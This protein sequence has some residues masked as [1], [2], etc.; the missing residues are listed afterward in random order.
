M[1]FA[2]NL[3]TGE[4]IWRYSYRDVAGGGRSAPALV[5]NRLV[6]GYGQGLIALN[7]TTGMQLWRSGVVGAPTSE[8][9]SS[10]AVTGPAGSQVAFVGDTA[11]NVYAFDLATGARQWSSRAGTLVYSSAAVSGAR[12]FFTSNNGLL[13]AYGLGG[14]VSSPPN[15]TV[16]NP[17]RNTTLPAASNATVTGSASDDV[18]VSEVRVAV[19]D[20]NAA[21]WWNAATRAW[22]RDFFDNP[23]SATAAGA[24]STNWTFTF[25]V[26]VTGG[27]FL[28]QASAI[29]TDHQSDPTAAS[30]N[31]TVSSSGNP[32][33]TTITSPKNNTVIPFPNG[34]ASFPIDV[35]GQAT[36]SG[37]AH[38]GI[39]TVNVVV[40]NLQHSEY[41]CG[42]A[43]CPD[44]AGGT[45]AWSAT[46]TT[47]HADLVS[48]G[49]T[50]TAWKLTFQAYDHP[51]DYRI[52]AWAVD[53]DREKDI[54]HARVAKV[55]VRDPGTGC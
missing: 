4:Q 34:R 12:V 48:P 3:R 38:P 21:R 25:P 50:S 1:I 29:D 19:R 49:A 22:Q 31:F 16:T 9:I 7:A 24:T 36:D 41:W 42:P 28:V 27:V 51:H 26:A 30:T 47:V 17:L 54:T 53:K 13:Y 15:T 43:G 44:G 32:P 45:V 11:G 20:Q 33:D 6:F 35:S 5:G 23:A 52:T 40:E 14:G 2:L 8:V 39:A 55:C 18:G 46:F 37:G 10:P